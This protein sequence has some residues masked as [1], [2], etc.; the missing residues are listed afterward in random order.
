MSDQGP[1]SNAELSPL[2]RTIAAKLSA[3]SQAMEADLTRFV[4]IPTG[5]GYSEGLAK[6]RA[7]M[8]ARLTALGA[9]ISESRGLTVRNEGSAVPLTPQ[10]PQREEAELELSLRELEDEWKCASS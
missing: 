2:E 9:D 3:R 4:A 10:A 1:E 8:R 7:I 5:T 6:F